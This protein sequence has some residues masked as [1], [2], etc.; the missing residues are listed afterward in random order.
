MSGVVPTARRARGLWVLGLPFLVGAAPPLY[1]WAGNAASVEV[2]DVVPVLAVV[3]GL[4]AA[5]VT[6]LLLPTRSVDRVSLTVAL[7]SLP[8]ATF[9]WQLQWLRGFSPALE[10]STLLVVEAVLLA[11]LVTAVW[12]LRVGTAARYL[13]VA[14]AVFCLS[15]L[16]GIAGGLSFLGAPDRT[17]GGPRADGPDIYFIVLDGYGR[18]DVLARWY[19]YD[20]RPFLDDL[21]DRGF[22]VARG[23][24][25]NYS[26]TYLSLAAT[27]NMN[28]VPEDLPYDYPAAERMVQ[29]AAVI[30]ALRERGYAYVAFETEFWV[31]AKAPLADVVHR[32]GPFE[33]E[34]ERVVIEASLL[35]YVLPASDRHE[36]VLNTFADLA[37]VAERPEPT[38]TFVHLLVPHPPFMFRADGTVLPYASDLA[39]GFE[40]RPYVE[41]LQFVNGRVTE[42][43]DQILAA[44]SAEP[45]IIIQGDHGPQ[46]FPYA[47]PAE[48][49][50]ER[51]GILNAMLVPESV[52]ER[53]YPS[54]S[55]VNTFRAVLG[56]LFDDGLP[57]LEDRVFYN[58][59]VSWDASYPGDHL[60]LFEVTD[61]LPWNIGP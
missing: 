50:W 2:G 9:G 47:P 41:Q 8:A 10:A 3:M 21:A 52:R 36:T 26:M 12:R 42:V 31:T 22:Y 59:Y 55:A 54:I 13:S 33:S 27:L 60:R 44:S 61:Q 23:S 28:Y 58:W 4:T 7:L 18:D 15:T 56:G 32:R 25:A 48:R 43:V 38:F 20:N 1:V 45:I 17:A 16:P 24:Y 46:A 30:H 5:A 57:L 19:D 40:A 39:A 34:F 37:E 53:L 11:V 51:H 6:L 49:Y 35:S 14:A 29:D